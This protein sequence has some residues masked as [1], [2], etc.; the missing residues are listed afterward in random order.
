MSL[1]GP[2]L[3]STCIRRDGSYGGTSCRT[4][5]KSGFFSLTDEATGFDR[6]DGKLRSLGEV[7]ADQLLDQCR[8][9]LTHLM[10]RYFADRRSSPDS[11]AVFRPKIE[12]VAG[13][14]AECLI[15]RVDI[16]QWA[17]DAEALR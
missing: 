7:S 1:P 9:D 4:L 8:V 15:P 6:R 5:Q 10:V 13:L 12:L 3:Q 14:Y 16:A 17:I 11:G 2:T